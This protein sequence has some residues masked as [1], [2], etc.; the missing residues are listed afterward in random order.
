MQ[1]TKT[2][3]ERADAWAFMTECDTLNRAAGFPQPVF[4]GG[5]VCR[6]ITGYTVTY[7]DQP[8]ARPGDFL[9]PA[10]VTR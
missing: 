2:F 9:I 3:T 8:T 7:E 4:E 1:Q 5:N 10:P 6:Q